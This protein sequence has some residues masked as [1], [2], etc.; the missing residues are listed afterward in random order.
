[1]LDDG[2]CKCIL[3]DSTLRDLVLKVISDIHPQLEI[4]PSTVFDE[5]GIS[6]NVRLRYWDRIREAMGPCC[7][8]KSA[9]NDISVAACSSPQ[10]ISDLIWKE[11]KWAL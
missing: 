4:F 7:E 2:S 3:T 5:A 9:V 6:K 11:R 8:V 1:M 10:K